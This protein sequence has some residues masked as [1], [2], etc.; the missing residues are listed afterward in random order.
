VSAATETP[1]AA[2]DVMAD[3]A[4]RVFAAALVLDVQAPAMHGQQPLDLPLVPTVTQTQ[5]LAARHAGLWLDA[6]ATSLLQPLDD[7]RT[8]GAAVAAFAPELKSAAA[9][10]AQGPDARA[11]DT[12]LTG[13]AHLGQLVSSRRQGIVGD[14]TAITAFASLVDDDSVRYASDAMLMRK[15]YTGPDGEITAI[16]TELESLAAKLRKDN[17]EIALGAAKALPAALI[18]GVGAGVAYINTSVGKAIVEKGIEMARG[19][20]KETDAAMDD[21]RATIAKYKE[22]SEKLSDERQQVA[23]FTTLN[24]HVTQLASGARAAL[25]ALDGLD[26]AWQGELDLFTLWNATARGADASPLPNA[27]TAAADRWASRSA[28]VLTLMR[29]LDDLPA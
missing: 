19:V 26:G 7:V 11:L 14:R 24:G 23:V 3:A 4:G 15:R 27:V 20:F 21:A 9:K 1:T 10:L 18:I 2:P 16:Q 17:E 29:A 13:I 22:K 6:Y 25:T 12:F 5:A 8:Y 28:G